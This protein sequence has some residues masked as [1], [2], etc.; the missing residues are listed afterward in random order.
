MV[1]NKSILKKHGI[2]YPDLGV[3]HRHVKLAWKLKKKELSIGDVIREIQSESD[4]DTTKVVLSS[5]DFC[6]IDIED[7]LRQL[8]RHYEVTAS[9]YLKRQELWLESWYN[10]HIKWPWSAKFSSS[11]PGFFLENMGDF[12]W[13]DYARL[14]KRISGVIGK[15]NL[16]V[17]V[18]DSAG[19]Y[20]TVDDL[21]GHIGIDKDWLSEY[22]EHNTSLTTA[23]IDI[24]RRINLKGVKPK[25][26]RRI[27]DA[28]D[29]L[30][31]EEDDGKKV[32]FTDAQ[33]C[34]VLDHFAK[35]NEVVA[36][37]YFSRKELFADPIK[38][39]RTPAFVEDRKAY[40]RYIPE[41]LKH[42]AEHC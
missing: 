16:Y 32:V 4:A 29:R 13:I 24:L 19:V 35:S 38:T 10:Q 23:K 20:N 34:M 26:R 6:L 15:S 14:L 27:I 33:V 12:Y 22:Q 17:N 21:L 9:I 37:E 3:S 41:L 39:G 36:K 2:L 42:I 7:W 1:K 8:S 28:L 11:T 40:R 25:A 5:E 30:D 18:V 31:V